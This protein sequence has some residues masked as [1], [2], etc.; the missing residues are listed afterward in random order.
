V[1]FYAGNAGLFLVLTYH[2]Q[3][4]LGLS[5]LAAG[6][7]FVPLGAGFALGS[8]T[9]RRLTVRFGSR[10]AVVGAVLMAVS[11]AVVPLAT[12]AGAVSQSWLVALIL[13]ISGVGQGLV[14]AS[15][16]DTVLSLVPA[17]DVGA[18]SGVLNTLTRAGMATG[19][20]ALGA[21]YQGTLGA[22][23]EAPSIPLSPED[24]R[25]AFDTSVMSLAVLAVFT[26]VLAALVGRIPTGSIPDPAPPK[27][28]AHQPH[29]T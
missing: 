29:S 7:V 27:P 5:P 13:G 1:L 17:H 18:G 15:L 21:L 10:V 25:R 12:G 14:V 20:A 6:L 19:I 24:F 3:A 23:P 16:V 2:L 8:S 11:L 28:L 9:S 26:A 22:N 4:G